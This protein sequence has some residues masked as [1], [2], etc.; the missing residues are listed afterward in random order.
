MKDRKPT[1]P[2]RVK[3]IPVPG[4]ESVFDMIRADEPEQ[5]GTPLNK[6]TLLT[7]EAATNVW[8]DEEYKPE[9]PTV[10]DALS[11]LGKRTMLTDE[12]AAKYG[13]SGDNATA[14]KA[15]EA[16]VSSLIG[17]GVT[18]LTVLDGDGNPMPNV[19]IN[20]VTG[21]NG[22]VVTTDSNGVAQVVVTASVD[23]TFVSGY[24]DVPD[25][26]QTLTPNYSEINNII[27]TL[28]Y[29]EAG[30]FSLFNTSQTLKFHKEHTVNLSV[31]GGGAGGAGGGGGYTYTDDAGDQRWHGGI[32][33]A[34]GAS[35][36]VYNVTNAEVSGE[37]ALAIG[38]GGEGSAG[39]NN[40]N[41]PTAGTAGGNTTFGSLSSANGSASKTPIG[42]FSVGGKGG[43][44][45]DG[46]HMVNGYHDY[47][48]GEA[49]SAG[50]R[51]GGN[52]GGGHRMNGGTS[53]SGG[54]IIKNGS[55]GENGYA[56]TNGGGGGGGGGGGPLMADINADIERH[57]GGDGGKGGSGCLVIGWL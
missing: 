27:V 35:G 16:L 8:P 4:E 42:S 18:T 25:Y 11:F 19:A 7:D 30:T 41:D 49:G 9:D 29:V 45:G 47:S 28:P 57:Y 54:T 12:V 52:G 32:G 33:G 51:G 22:D 36:K 48:W 26:V 10:N 55:K 24:A 2:G 15:F 21:V 1:Y 37:M 31:V 53:P 13:L 3:L 20:G 17:Q 5:D 39:K 44:G 43:N 46:G 14:N 23:V 56:G 34:G 38:A 6:A 50:V 40:G